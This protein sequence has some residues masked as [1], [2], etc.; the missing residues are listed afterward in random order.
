MALISVWR[1]AGMPSG[2]YLAA[3]MDLLRPKL[4]ALGELTVV[5]FSPEDRDQQ[6][7]DSGATIDKL[8]RSTRTA[9]APKC[10]SPTKAGSELRS[11][12]A[13]RRAGQEHEQVP[14]FTE[15]D[16]VAHYGPALMGDSPRCRPQRNS[17][18]APPRFIVLT[19]P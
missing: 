13:V 19:G 4:E 10:L 11:A 5:R 8:L 12:I 15:A 17:P 16:L 2:K 7:A 9:M 1:L 3:A 14:G 6:M 18:A